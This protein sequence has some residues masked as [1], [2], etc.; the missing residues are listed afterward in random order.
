MQLA[1]VLKKNLFRVVALIFELPN[2]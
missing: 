1:A 2:N